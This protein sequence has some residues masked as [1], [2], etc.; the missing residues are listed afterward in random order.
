MMVFKQVDVTDVTEN[1]GDKPHWEVEGNG[2][3]MRWRRQA[4]EE[5][6]GKWAQYEVEV[7]HRSGM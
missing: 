1:E 7:T 3:G 6:G 4:A 5:G 2:Y